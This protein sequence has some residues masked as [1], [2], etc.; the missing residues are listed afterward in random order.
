MAV[1]AGSETPPAATRDPGVLLEDAAKAWQARD[2]VRWTALWDVGSRASEEDFARAAFAVDVTTLEWLRRGS[3]GHGST[4]FSVDAEVFTAKEPR[5]RLSYWRLTAELRPGGWAFVSRSETN[6]VEGLVHVSLSGHAWRAHG[7]SLR[8]ED[9]ELRLEDGTLFSNPEP[10]DPTVLVFVGRG[11]VRVDPSPRAEREQLRRFSGDPALDVPIKWCFVR[12]HPGDLGRLIDTSQLEPD[13]EAARRLALAQR[14]FAER[15][16]RSFALDAPL[17]GSPWWLLPGAGD[18]VVDF[19]WRRRVLTFALS[20]SEA[21]DVN[22]FDRDRQ[23]QICM[24]P[25]AA[26]AGQPSALPS[27]V[28]TLDQD[29]S[30]RFEPEQ[31]ELTAVHRLRLRSVVASTLR[32]RLDDDFRVSSVSSADGTPLLFF[33]VRGQGSIVVSL[34]GIAERDQPFTVVTRYAGRHDPAPVE[35]ELLQV[36]QFRSFSSSQPIEPPPIVYSNR[37]AWYPHP[38]EETF[39]P[40]TA[41]FD[42]PEG[43]LAVTGGELRALRTEARRTHAEYRLAQPGKYVTAVVGRL[44]EVGLRQTGE[45]ALRA[46]S[47]PRSRFMGVSQMRAAEQILTFYAE[48]FG[49]CP[50]PSLALVAVEA[51]VPGGHSPPGLVYLQEQPAALRGEGMAEDPA[52]FSD[53]PDFF[54]A[55]ELA[56]QWFGQGV[57][58]AGYRERW[59]SEA[60]AQ[61]AAALWVRQR[62]GEAAFRDMMDTMARWAMRHDAA[63]PIHLGQR[64][65]ALEGDMRLY[66]AIVYDKGAWVLHMLRG[67]VGDDAFFLG[68]RTFLERH[69]FGKVVTGDLRE[70]L[71]QASGRDLRPYFER[72]INETGLPH[73]TW[74]KQTRQVQSGFETTV[75]MRASDTPGPLPV[76]ISVST[77]AGRDVRRVTLAPP[78]GSWTITSRERPRGI[79]VNEDRG[80]LAR[81]ESGRVTRPDQR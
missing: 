26:R 65:G 18:A 3:P 48:R 76:S 81:V 22:L 37:T 47:T 60:W 62:Q 25:S 71:E 51:R 12:M 80:L 31:L 52:N 69:R 21:E 32:L 67:I 30:V 46:F 59:L 57:A 41:S 61:Y 74:S 42:T 27:A 63:G 14:I 68:T 11:R 43:W 29:L 44:S 38:V 24:Y 79:A 64:I 55:H 39:S 73:I 6:V 35:H 54:V 16:L 58:P 2:L 72:W 8:L 77:L 36:G 7:V 4:R 75:T 20:R 33:R 53:L 50:Y 5:G 78:L 1:F 34:G 28:E 66:R 15:S 56:H 19:P 10:I 17:P 45:Q 9:F 70:A 40:L 13:P 23:I 49:P